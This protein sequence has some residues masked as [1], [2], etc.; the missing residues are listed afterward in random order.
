VRSDELAKRGFDT[1]LRE[2]ARIGAERRLVE[3]A[4]EAAA[5]HRAFPE[6]R[7]RR[8]VSRTPGAETVTRPQPTRR[9]RKLSAAGRERLRASLK[10]RWAAAKKAGKT[11]LS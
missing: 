3:I 9:G 10:K 6:L 2:W 11:K 8:E 1:D 7:S 4:E 5:I